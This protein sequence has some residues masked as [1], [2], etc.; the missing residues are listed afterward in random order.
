MAV[1]NTP[2]DLVKRAI[3]SVLCQDFQAFELIILDDGSDGP[4][5]EKM[6]QYSRLHQSKVTYIR[7]QNC[8]QAQSINRGTQYCR[9]AYITII[10]SD[11]EYKPSHLSACLHQMPHA[12]LICSLTETV[13]NTEEDHYVPDRHDPS[14]NIRVDDCTLFA[15]FFGKKEVFHHLSFHNIYAA[16]ADFYARAAA[17]YRVKKVDLRTYIYYRNVTGSTCALLKQAQLALA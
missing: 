6:L 10:D 14:K 12:D 5:G 2:F 7:H 9:G 15:T 1:Y 4:L 3:D 13:V 16:D 11:D 8:G 17:K